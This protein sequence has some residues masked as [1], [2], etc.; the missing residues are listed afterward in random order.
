M[1]V[2]KKKHHEHQDIRC[3]HM[4]KLS[5]A[6][7]KRTCAKQRTHVLGRDVGTDGS[8]QQDHY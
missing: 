5:V 3:Q 2:L 4:C 1:Q 8:Q 6:A 7:G